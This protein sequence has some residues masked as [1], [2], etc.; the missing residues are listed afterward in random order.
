MKG[1]QQK[2]LGPIFDLTDIS[3]LPDGLILTR[4]YRNSISVRLVTLLKEADFPLS[5]NQL[6]A[7]YYRRYIQN[8]ESATKSCK[9]IGGSLSY[10]AR[11]DRIRR[12]SLGVYVHNGYKGV[13]I[14]ADG[15]PDESNLPRA[16]P[17]K[18]RKG[19]PKKNA[20]KS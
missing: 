15:L 9:S 18:K 1:I 5:K 6:K 2:Q 11:N 13:I 20:T 4:I 3:D 12:V 14:G 16:D 17:I 7:A 10:L 19:R 8:P